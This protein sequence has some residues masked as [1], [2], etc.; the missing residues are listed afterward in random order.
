M[1]REF[2][3]NSEKRIKLRKGMG[4]NRGK[5]EREMKGKEIRVQREREMKR[6]QREKCERG[7]E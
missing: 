4:E 2:R 7:G 6:F 5:L 3:D 1:R